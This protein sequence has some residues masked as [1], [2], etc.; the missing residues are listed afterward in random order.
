MKYHSTRG[1]APHLG[2]DDA[3]LTGLAN[4]GGLYL[5]MEWPFVSESS[6]LSMQ[7]LSYSE[8]ASRVVNPFI[9]GSLVENDLDQIIADTYNKFNHPDV[10]PMMNLQSNIWIMELYHG[11]TLAFKDF[12]LQIINLHLLIMKK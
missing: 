6:W 7:G 4:D 10:A 8:L 1:Q 2:F 11:P 3:L 5:P 9:K 12:A